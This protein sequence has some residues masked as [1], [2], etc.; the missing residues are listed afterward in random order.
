MQALQSTGMDFPKIVNLLDAALGILRVLPKRVF[1]NCEGV[2]RKITWA[3]W[4]HI[5]VEAAA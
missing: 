5:P 1:D 4:T 2:Y 3:L